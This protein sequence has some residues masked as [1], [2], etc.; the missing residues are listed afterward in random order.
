MFTIARREAKYKPKFIK[1][2]EVKYQVKNK[3]R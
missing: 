1:E 3:E 2:R